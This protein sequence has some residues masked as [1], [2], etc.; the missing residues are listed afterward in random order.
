[1]GTLQTTDWQIKGNVLKELRVG[2]RKWDSLTNDDWYYEVTQK[3]VDVKLGMDITI[4][5]YEKL[6]DTM[7]LIAGDS[8][9]VPAAKQ[10]RI[11]GIDFI[12]NPLK[13]RISPSLSEHVDGIQ[14]FNIGVA[15]TEIFKCD[16]EGN[17]D[18]WE[19]FKQHIELNK[20]KK[21]RT[22]KNLREIGRGNVK[23]CY[24]LA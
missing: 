18:W 4:L 3:S 21:R 9:F 23:K 13:Q 7:V 1:M 15:L 24:F 8:D 11:K 20:K 6:V 14:S 22:G 17:P 16:P 5:A 12:L 19:E 2:K 10:A